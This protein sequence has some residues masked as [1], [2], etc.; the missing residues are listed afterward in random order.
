VKDSHKKSLTN[1]RREMRGSR[2]KQERCFSKESRREWRSRMRTRIGMG[3]R[4]RVI[5]RRRKRKRRSCSVGRKR[6]RSR[7]KAGKEEEH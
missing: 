6:R 2:K 1:S 4:Y 3:S 5:S 7:K